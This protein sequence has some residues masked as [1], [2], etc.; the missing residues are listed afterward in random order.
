MP[1]IQALVRQAYAK[2]IPATGRK[3]VPMT[4]DYA[5]AVRLHR[6]DLL[7]QDG[8]LVALIETIPRADHLWVENLAVA[9]AQQG[10]GLGRRMLRR[11]EDDARTLGHTTIKL[12]TNQAYASNVDFYRRAGYGVE[13]EEPFWA[14]SRSISPRRSEL[15]RSRQ[16][17]EPMVQQSTEAWTRMPSA[18]SNESFHRR[19]G[20]VPAAHDAD[21]SAR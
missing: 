5:L 13:R 6:F 7:E 9:P 19:G 8:A 1:A 12:G 3:P 14:A 21:A 2:W 15:S 10:Q 17:H 4:A 16:P 18:P 11:A 20:I